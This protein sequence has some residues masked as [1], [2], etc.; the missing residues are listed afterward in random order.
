MLF[1]T[2]AFTSTHGNARG[3]KTAS[4]C[5]QKARFWTGWSDTATEGVVT[6]THT[7]THSFCL[8]SQ[9]FGERTFLVSHRSLHGWRHYT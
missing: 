4:Q 1:I 7:Y 2:Q 3:K 9:D 8:T 6:N 5:Q